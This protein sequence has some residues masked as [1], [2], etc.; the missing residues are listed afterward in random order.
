MSTPCPY[1][2]I[3]CSTND[4]LLLKRPAVI[5]I[6]THAVSSRSQSYHSLPLHQSLLPPP[7]A[8]ATSLLPSRVWTTLLCFWTIRPSY[9][10]DI[11]TTTAGNS[12]N[13]KSSSNS[14]A[15]GWLHL[16]M[17]NES[18]RYPLAPDRSFPHDINQ[19][20]HHIL[21]TTTPA[22]IVISI[23]IRLCSDDNGNITMYTLLTERWMKQR[24]VWVLNHLPPPP[25]F[26]IPPP[27]MLAP[28]APRDDNNDNGA[29][30]DDNNE[31]RP[32]N[33]TPTPT[34]G[35]HD[36]HDEPLHYLPPTMQYMDEFSGMTDVYIPSSLPCQSLYNHIRLQLETS[37]AC[38]SSLLVIILAY[39]L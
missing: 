19:P 16:L 38:P 24:R 23:D 26:I 1:I 22:D 31:V 11:S 15:R 37:T 10:T 14:R 3:W 5:P 34:A 27:D 20:H 18:E 6:T 4:G 32:Y 25:E 9:F 39:L 28:V 29:M 36:H 8:A 12:G 7:P 17:E 2:G 30:N 13:S 21:S 33:A 35:D